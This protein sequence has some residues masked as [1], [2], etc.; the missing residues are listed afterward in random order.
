M[1]KFAILLAAAAL[2]AS[3]AAVAKSKMKHRAKVDPAVAAEKMDKG[4]A[5]YRF[6][7]DALPLALPSWALPIYFSMKKS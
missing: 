7:R 4:E 5:S 1:K 6:M 2:V 3:P